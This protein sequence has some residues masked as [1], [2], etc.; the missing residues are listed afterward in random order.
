MIFGLSNSIFF[1]EGQ[2]RGDWFGPAYWGQFQDT[3]GRLLWDSIGDYAIENGVDFVVVDTELFQTPDPPIEIFEEISESD[4]M[5][6]V[7]QLR[8][9]E[10]Q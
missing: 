7:L 5:I 8:R 9:A 1:Y 4:S 6:L 2:V 10:E 3:E